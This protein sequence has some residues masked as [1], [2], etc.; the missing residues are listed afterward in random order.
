MSS[1][2]FHGIPTMYRNTRFRSRLEARWARMLDS[3]G[4]GWQ[5]EPID[6]DGY[7]PDFIVRFDNGPLLIE[8]KPE[9][10][11]DDLA[12]H[13]SKIE[14]SGWEH[15][16]LIVGGCLF[17]TEHV[18][19]VIGSIGERIVG[20]D[21]EL[22]W[23]WDSARL[24]RCTNCGQSSVLSEGGSWHCRVCGADSDHVGGSVEAASEWVDA[25]NRVQWRAGA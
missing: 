14:D 11:F 25:G 18:H 17:E 12:Q 7:I 15:E 1:K 19:P 8:V 21:G 24:F 20:P 9:L 5:Y 16:A 2:V 6:L 10:A 13:R 23:L 4:W 22:G 3:L